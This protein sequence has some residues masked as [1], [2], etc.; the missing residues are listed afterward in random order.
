[1]DIGVLPRDVDAKIKRLENDLDKIKEKLWLYHLDPAKAKAMRQAIK[2]T[3]RAYIKL[4]SDRHSLD[5]LTIEG[6]AEMARTL[7][8][9]SFCLQKINGEKVTNSSHLIEKAVIKVS[10]EKSTNEEIR[11]LARTEPWKSIW[12]AHGD[13][14]FGRETTEEQRTLILYSKMYDSVYKSSESPPEYIIHDDDLLDGWI[15]HQRKESEREKKTSNK[16]GGPNFDADEIYLFKD[17]KDG[18]T[19]NEFISETDG[20]NSLEAKIIKGQRSA[21]LKVKGKLSEAQLPD[22]Q[23]EL[24][25]QAQ[26]QVMDRLKRK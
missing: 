6:Y 26:Q 2:D 3:K 25:M 16:K 4:L 15:I 12:N 17:K 8:L 9:F 1:M 19:D 24:Q 21:A 22:I 13:R 20:M 10:S 14:Y 5:H 23:R 18:R 11:E 7:C